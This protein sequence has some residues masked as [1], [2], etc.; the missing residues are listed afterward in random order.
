M[1]IEHLLRARQIAKGFSYNT[2]LKLPPNPDNLHI[3]DEELVSGRLN[4]LLRDSVKVRNQTQGHSCYIVQLVT[5][6]STYSPTDGDD[7]D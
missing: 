3:T 5:H 6:Q 2:L 1:F 4:Q 7:N